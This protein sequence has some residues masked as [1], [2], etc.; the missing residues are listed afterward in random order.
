MNDN[1]LDLLVNPPAS[2]EDLINKHFPPE[3]VPT[4]IRVAKAESTLN[5]EATNTN[6]NGT[7]DSGLFQINDVN[8]PELQE[9]GIISSRNDLFDPETNTKA[10]A[11][12][13][14]QYGFK[15]WESSKSKWGPEQAVETNKALDEATKDNAL[16]ALATE[17]QKASV[18]S[19]PM[20]KTANYLFQKFEKGLAATVGGWGDLANLLREK[21]G[22]KE[23]SAMPTTEDIYNY[24][25]KPPAGTEVLPSDVSAP[26]RI[27]GGGAEWTGASLIPGANAARSLGGMKTF[28]NLMKG[29]SIGGFSQA[30]TAEV[31]DNPLVQAVAGIAGAIVG[32]GVPGQ[33]RQ[34]WKTRPSVIEKAIADEVKNGVDKSGIASVPNQR[35]AG[36]RA[37]YY[38]NAQSGVEDI[39]K[40]KPNL[41]LSDAEPGTLPTSLPQYAEGI[42]QTKR[43]IYK[44]ID[45]EK[46]AAGPARVDLTGI[47]SKLDNIINNGG[48][49][50]T[51]SGMKLVDYAQKTKDYLLAQGSVSL[52]EAETMLQKFNTDMRNFWKNPKVDAYHDLMTEALVANS[53]RKNMDSVV[54]NFGE[55]NKRYGAL[56]ALED[57]VNRRATVGLRKSPR[58]LVDMFDIYSGQQILDSALTLNPNKLKNALLITVSKEVWK[59]FRDPDNRVKWMFE[60]TEKLMQKR[61]GGIPSIAPAA[62]PAPAPGVG[63]AP[64]TPNI[65]PGPSSP[66]TGLRA[67]YTPPPPSNAPQIPWSGT[68]TIEV[69]PTGEATVV[70][71]APAPAEPMPAPEVARAQAEAK[72]PTQAEAQQRAM[73]RNPESMTAYEMANKKT[74][75]VPIRRNWMVEEGQQN[76]EAIKSNNLLIQE[77][78][79]SLVKSRQ[80][81]LTKY[82]TGSEKAQSVIQKIS[83]AKPTD[84]SSLSTDTR[85]NELANTPGFLHTAEDKVFL[86]GLSDK[87]LVEAVRRN[88]DIQTARVLTSRTQKVQ[89]WME[90]QG[91]ERGIRLNEALMYLRRQ[92]P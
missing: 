73:V 83:D 68:N 34:A 86:K 20:G 33:I 82:G 37:K 66:L 53:V 15:P 65:P 4:A 70:N 30:G 48:L 62:T 41:Q 80:K 21:M 7:Q 29:A 54:K 72:A 78:M 9:A 64:V 16:D 76:L 5:P 27:L 81:I 44:M 47:A 11:Y 13:H 2:H 18:S 91:K 42:S 1:A 60:N 59:H 49:R 31:T 19:P 85:I 90:S 12:L 77:H 92:L 71:K 6:K 89:S 57:D 51:P 63:P 50:A 24:L 84:I 67:G 28:M 88:A 87:K 32:G 58:G 74:P 38:K 23:K 79:D 39:I 10:A 36:M 3:A 69:G 22:Y 43:E 45:A 55:L 35:N 56:R 40:N 52:D 61:P 14:S 8:I 17:P 75:N 25:F 26:L 46:T